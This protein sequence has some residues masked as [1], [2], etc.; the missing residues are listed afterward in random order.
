MLLSLLLQIKVLFHTAPCF[1]SLFISVFNTATFIQSLTNV[2]IIIPL[3]ILSTS[4]S[5]L[6]E[7]LSV[8]NTGTQSSSKP[9][10][11]LFGPIS[12]HRLEYSTPLDI[13]NPS[14]V[15]HSHRE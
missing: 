3:N 6:V 12:F 7:P 14:V 13:L 10:T 4:L 2:G 11:D 8:T 5:G 1:A 9:K 15:F